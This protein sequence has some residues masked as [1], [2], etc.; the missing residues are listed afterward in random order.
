MPV[1]QCDIR[2]GWSDDQKR[3]LAQGL[4]K[5]VAEVGK[6]PVKSIHIVIREARGLHYCFGGE[7]VPEFKASGG[8]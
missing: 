7:H 8:G 3:A 1:I 6:V 5:V 2:E 4:T